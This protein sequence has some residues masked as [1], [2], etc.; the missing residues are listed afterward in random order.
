M[1]FI[2]EKKFFDTPALEKIEETAIKILEE[3]G[4]S[5]GHQEF[6]EMALAKGFKPKNGRI[7]L[8][9]AIVKDFIEEEQKKNEGYDDSGDWREHLE[10]PISIGT[11]PYP[12]NYHNLE[13]DEIVPFTTDKLIESVKLIDSF[14]DEGI[15]LGAP[16]YPTDVPPVLQPLQQYRIL[17]TYSRQGR[18]PVDAKYLESLPYIM[19]MAAL[20]GNPIRSLPVYVFSPLNLSGESLKCVL[21]FKERLNSVSISNMPSVGSTAPI[22][23]GDALGMASAE[24][25]GSAIIVREVLGLEVQWEISLLPCDLRTMS[26]TFGSPEYILFQIAASEVDAY[27]HRRK[28][29][30]IWSGTILTSAKLP[31]PHSCLDKMASMIFYAMMGGRHFTG[32]GT[33]ALDEVFSPEQFIYDF[34]MKNYVN[35]FIKGLDSNCNLERTVSEVREGISNRSF[36]YLES[37][38]NLHRSVYWYPRVLNR[39]SLRTW[40]NAGSPKDKERVKEI[41][42]E[43]I[44][45]HEYLIEPELRK[46]IE[47]MYKRAEKDCELNNER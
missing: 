24:V 15:I 3:I 35:R 40:Q 7:I 43:K 26:M 19:E 33:L 44:K 29:E 2:R 28:L 10:K 8:E 31:G 16:G 47:K 6:L 39:K 5:I 22:R 25:I 46:E 9:R 41:V 34:E 36:A 23:I 30:E 1:L 12:M 11:N 21:T 4:I 14:K 13:T 45:S 32:A 42:R 17:A 18:Y 37:T 38:V 27:L 20:L